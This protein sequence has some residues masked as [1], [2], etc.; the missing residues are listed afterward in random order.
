MAKYLQHPKYSRSVDY[1]VLIDGS[2]FDVEVD[3]VKQEVQDALVF[4]VKE[5]LE[6]K[7]KELLVQ[8]VQHNLPHVARVRD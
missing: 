5:G 3:Y 2:V 1:L 7:H 4:A 6:H 8:S